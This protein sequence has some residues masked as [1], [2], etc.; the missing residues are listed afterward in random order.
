MEVWREHFSK[1]LGSR[2]ESMDGDEEQ[3]GESE[4]I[5]SGDTNGLDFCERLC[6]AISREEVAWSLAKVKKDAAAGKDEVTVNM[7]SAEVLFDV[8]FALFE[9]CWEY[10]V[11]SSV[12][13]ESLVV[14]IPKKQ[15]RGTCDTNTYRGISLMS[16]VSKVYYV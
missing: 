10:G 2:N 13:R 7:M 6:Q 14:P 8:W 15:A 3:R 5:N 4:A 16:T 9:V 1:V 12:W 11:V